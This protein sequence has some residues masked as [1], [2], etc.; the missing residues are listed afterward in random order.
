MRA[1]FFPF[2]NHEIKL[3][4]CWDLDKCL[5]LGCELVSPS[6]I[7]ANEFHRIRASSQVAKWRHQQQQSQRNFSARHREPLAATPAI[8]KPTQLLRASS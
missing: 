7:L 2:P 5:I 6:P 3:L 8:A 4:A 1:M